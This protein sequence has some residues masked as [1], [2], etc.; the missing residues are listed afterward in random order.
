MFFQAENGLEFFLI[1]LITLLLFMTGYN[2]EHIFNILN[3][4]A[5]SLVLNILSTQTRKRGA[6]H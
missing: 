6:P 5:L 3:K 1:Y 2:R 4:F